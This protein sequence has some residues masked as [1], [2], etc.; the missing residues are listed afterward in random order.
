MAF[1]DD[2]SRWSG[3]LTNGFIGESD[4]ER[5]RKQQ[6][7][8]AKALQATKVAANKGNKGYSPNNADPIAFNTRR[9]QLNK[10]LDAGQSYE[11]LSK[12]LGL[13]VEAVRDYTDTTRPGYGVQAKPVQPQPQQQN[14]NMLELEQFKT[15]QQKQMD[16]GIVKFQDKV[17]TPNKDGTFTDQ[18]GNI[19]NG[20]TVRKL[21]EIESR[22]PDKS[23]ALTPLDVGGE[24][25]KAV[26]TVGKTIAQG[27]ARV[28]ETVFRSAI[29]EPL[30]GNSTVSP[31][32]AMSTASDK[33]TGLRAFLYGEDAVK[34]YQETAREAQIAAENSGNSELEAIAP[35]APFIAPALGALDLSPVAAIKALRGA[36]AIEEGADAT[37]IAQL[38]QKGTGD[39]VDGIEREAGRKLTDAERSAVAQEVE[40]KVADEVAKE[41]PAKVADEIIPNNN[42]LDEEGAP[43]L[44]EI[45]QN[46][47]DPEIPGEIPRIDK[48]TGA[49]VEAGTDVYDDRS[50]FRAANDE[51]MGS[52]AG[53]TAQ[54]LKDDVASQAY[55]PLSVAQ[56]YDNQLYGDLKSRGEILPGQRELLP[57]QSMTQTIQRI[58]NP[59]DAAGVLTGK[60]F[61]VNGKE[62]SVDDVNK[63][64]GKQD[65]KKAKEF[66]DYRI[67]RDQLERIKLG[68]E[69]TLPIDP[70]AMQNFVDMMD[71]Q[72]P[73]MAE[74]ATVL[75]Q[76]MGELFKGKVD[77]GI[78]SPEFL[79]NSQKYAN[80]NPRTGT[81][82]DDLISPTVTAATGK[83]TKA[84]EGRLKDA[85]GQLVSSPMQLFYDV[86]KENVQSVASKDLDN[87]FEARARDSADNGF[88]IKVD[89]DVARAHR[90]SANE[91]KKLSDDIVKMRT[92]VKGAK[93]DSKLAGNYEKTRGQAAKVVR[94]YLKDQSAD[95]NA[96]QF[97]KDISD[98]EAIELLQILHDTGEKSSAR[99][100]NKL[101]KSTGISKAEAKKSL[102]EARGAL[103]ETREAKSEAYQNFLDT[104]QYSSRGVQTRSYRSKGETGKIELPVDISRMLSKNAETRNLSLVEKGLRQVGNVQKTALT[105]TL[106]PA[107]KAKQALIDNNY[108]MYRNGE[109]LSSFRPS[110]IAK[111][112]E[113]FFYPKGTKN[114]VNELKSNGFRLENALQSRRIDKTIADNIASRAGVKEFIM[115]NPKATASDV[116]G[117]ISNGV[118]RVNNAQ[119]VQVAQGAYRKLRRANWSHEDAMKYAAN[120]PDRVFGD[121][122]RVSQLAQDLEA[123]IPYTSATQAGLRAS[124]RRNKVAPAET[125]AK[126]LAFL[127]SVAGITAYSLGN[128]KEYY[129]DAIKDGREYELDSNVIIALPWA[130]KNDKGE[131]DGVLKIPIPPDARPA[132]RATWKA[133]YDMT[134]GKGVD[135]VMIASNAFAQLTGDMPNNVYDGKNTNDG[136][137][138]VNGVLS[139]SPV[140]S[141][142]KILSGV[143]PRTGDPL[144]D[145]FMRSKKR[146]DQYYEKTETSNG[147]SQAAKDLSKATG[148]FITPLQADKLFG[149]TGQFGKQVK[150]DEGFDASEFIDPRRY[151]KPG[152]SKTEEQRKTSAY[153]AEVT[154]V[155]TKLA[156]EG[157]QQ[158]YK[159]F[160]ALHAKKSDDQKKNMLNNASK[161]MKFM[162]YNGDGAFNTTRLFE[163][164]KEL[165]AAARKRGEPGNPLFDL[166]PQEIQKVL[167]YRA[168]KANNAAK[169]NYTKNGMP[170]FTALGLDQRWYKEF[171]DKESEY[172]AKVLKEGDDEFRTFSGKKKPKLSAEQ[173]AIQNKYFDLKDAGD[174]DGA[175][176]LLSG[177]QWLVDSWAA[178]NDFT[179]EERKAMGF[180]ADYSKDDPRSSNYNGGYGGRGGKSNTPN[181]G[182]ADTITSFGNKSAGMEQIN[183]PQTK[184]VNVRQAAKQP[185]RAT[186]KPN[187]RITI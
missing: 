14:K 40:K 17:Y 156:Q 47:A 149:L 66:E 81:R 51:F 7:Q 4:E 63:I 34:S 116:L 35:L 94:Q 70:K 153:F 77:A 157:D 129:D 102:E 24:I 87:L 177:N 5:R 146:T 41:A 147:T 164:E 27:V 99:L 105:G 100:I 13:T 104:S 21:G 8:A 30:V 98:D 118:A 16:A 18:D 152:Q 185:R 131:W 82:P 6:E 183:G 113:Y 142:G 107:F 64:Y 167:M 178:G 2:V 138:P 59:E 184:L 111:G 140:A 123:A 22:M 101:A 148:G 103:R 68:E 61:V 163:A 174:D 71:N 95:A 162:Q 110:A 52:R 97:A 160:L 171:T 173:D 74:H 108:L 12:N 85:R 36:K 120:A 151:L 31:E 133:T 80:Y 145:E 130:K 37:M 50:L 187:I 44:P 154:G 155:A 125:V 67:F 1:W 92:V 158:T 150:N 182:V 141:A 159:D 65:G 124:L 38:T 137:N 86:A 96:K 69:N 91:M 53:S 75:R 19:K 119:R 29:L 56:R 57:H 33:N 3:N 88:N 168:N 134:N 122:S 126:D 84:T 179:N 76:F 128:Q 127:S 176:A 143:D 161:M 58:N 73:E 62:F 43:Q 15:P 55:D 144:G 106:A 25:I 20:Q 115:R 60:K 132:A 79:V 169:Q 165:D 42:L 181:T 89:A 83:T 11:D 23:G 114:F 93:K 28:P 109:S 48:P 172:F 49:T 117:M 180:L 10:G 54:N 90:E 9:D 32:D 121:M 136:K 175:K 39:V 112:I 72:F 135:P 26:G 186:K 46:P 166:G 78:D 170:M 139:Q 45:G